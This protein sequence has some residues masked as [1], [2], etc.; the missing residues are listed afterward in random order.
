MGA[1]GAFARAHQDRRTAG[2]PK[3]GAPVELLS[4]DQTRQML[5]SDAWFGVEGMCNSASNAD[6]CEF[7]A[8]KIEL[9][10]VGP[11]VALVALGRD[12]EALV[13]AEPRHVR[14]CQARERAVVQFAGF[15]LRCRRDR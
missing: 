7:L 2:W 5:G 15:H 6:V 14:N 8:A 1:A 3:F 12:D 4:R 11:G 13:L 10:G 9:D